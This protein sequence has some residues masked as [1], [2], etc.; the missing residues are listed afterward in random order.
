M[1]TFF[2]ARAKENYQNIIQNIES[3]WGIFSVE[4]FQYQLNTFLDLLEKFPEIGFLENESKRIR[5][6]GLHQHVRIF[7]RIKN[8]KIVIL[9][10]FDTR[11]H[12]N[13]KG[14]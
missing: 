4:K 12:P 8:Q 3:E 5:S 2:T 13:K 10:L 1:R 7:Y 14:F 9:S 6:F 11:Q